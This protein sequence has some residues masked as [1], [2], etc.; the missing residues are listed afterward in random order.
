MN[1]TKM[2]ALAAVLVFPCGAA[3]AGGD[4]DAGRAKSEACAA[5]HGET[6]NGD[7]PAYPKLA[8][9]YRSYLEQALRDYRSGARSNAIMAGFATP[10]SDADIEDLA[11]YFST[12]DGDLHVLSGD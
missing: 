8:G 7:N 3:Y 11:A 5:C 12:Q 2:I 10:L 6:G 4:P 9:Q 1:T